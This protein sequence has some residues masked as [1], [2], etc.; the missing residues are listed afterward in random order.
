MPSAVPLDGLRVR[1][2]RLTGKAGFDDA[3]VEIFT[4]EVGNETYADAFGADG[5][6]L[7][8]IAARTKPFTIHRLEHGTHTVRAFRLPLRQDRKM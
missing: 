8:L 3:G 7:I 5:L 4:I 1:R 6:A 2:F